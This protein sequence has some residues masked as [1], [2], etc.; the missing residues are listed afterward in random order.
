M[1]DGSI[2]NFWD[3]EIF[4]RLE[5]DRIRRLAEALNAGRITVE[6]LQEQDVE[7]VLRA[8]GRGR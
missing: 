1:A 2:V 6:K 8:A 5:R 4:A 3:P 7:A